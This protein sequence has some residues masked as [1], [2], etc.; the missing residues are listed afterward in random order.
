MIDLRSLTNGLMQY[1]QGMLRSWFA[2]DME[3]EFRT[4][5]P[6]EALSYAPIWFGV[7]KIAGHVGQM[8]I[9]LYKRARNDGIEVVKNHPAVKTLRRPNPFMTHMKWAQTMMVHALLDGNGRC[10]IVRENGVPV[11]LIILN[12]QCTASII[13]DGIVYHVT[14]PPEWDRLRLFFEPSEYESERDGVIVLNDADVIHLTG[15]SEDG[16]SGIPLRK[17]CGRSIGAGIDADKRIA[18]QMKTGFVGKLFFEAPPG[19]FR[20]EEDA[21]NFLESVKERHS[22][23]RDAEDV[24]LLREGIK[25]NVI[26]MNNREAEMAALRI[27]QRQDAA[28]LLGL[29]G[30]LGDDTSVSYNSAEQKNL[31][32]LSMLS[33]WLVPFEQELEYKLLSTNEFNRNVYSFRFN[34]QQ[35]LK[36]DAKSTVETLSLAVTSEIMTKNEARAKLDLNPIKGGDE[37]RNPAINPAQS[38]S[39]PPPEEDDSMDDTSAR[40]AIRSRVEHLIN[41]ECGRVRTAAKQASTKGFNFLQWLDEFYDDKWQAKLA[42]WLEELGMD[43]DL[44]RLHC[45]ESKRRLLEITDYTQPEDLVCNVGK[46]IEKWPMR[47]YTIGETVCSAT[48]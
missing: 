38:P 14:R 13:A 40:N 34:T 16:V 20:K 31:A 25:A 3:R 6:H 42:N 7:S 32:Y 45:E 11:E 36:S 48:A 5:S 1:S 29:E 4:V 28:L 47:S 43:R 35:L 9:H 41:V 44:A 22:A 2:F 21:K 15:L 33:R 24:G 23:D 8:P 39:A 37:L 26:D 18:K 27:F 19:I 17:V 10:A 12:P 30:I 46:C